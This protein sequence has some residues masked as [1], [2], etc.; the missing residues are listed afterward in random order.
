MLRHAQWVRDKLGKTPALEA[1]NR[2]RAGIV[3]PL[4]RR[5]G[6]QFTGSPLPTEFAKQQ[7]PACCL[8]P[9]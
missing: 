4:K 1:I 3:R 6:K 2:M 5:S 9:A 7:Y 8:L